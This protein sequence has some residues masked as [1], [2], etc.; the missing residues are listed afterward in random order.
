M[1]IE[2]KIGGH[3]KPEVTILTSKEGNKTGGSRRLPFSTLYTNYKL[4][5]YKTIVWIFCI[6]K[7]K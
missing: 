7:G 6:I 1:Y 2:R 3:T 4:T 5:I